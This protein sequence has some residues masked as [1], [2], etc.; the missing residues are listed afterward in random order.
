MLRLSAQKPRRRT[1]FL[2]CNQ[3]FGEPFERVLTGTASPRLR[4]IV[5]RHRKGGRAIS[6]LRRIRWL[7][8]IDLRLRRGSGY[9]REY[10]VPSVNTWGFRC[11]IP[12]HAIGIIAGF[13]EIFAEDTIDS[14]EQ[15][16]NVHPSVLPYYRGPVPSY[17]ALKNAEQRS[18]FTVHE[19]TT[20]ID[21]GPILH[22]GSVQIPLDA[23]EAELDHQIAETAAPEVARWLSCL[24]DNRTF[25]GD[26]LDPASIYNHAVDYKSFPASNEPA[27]KS[28]PRIFIMGLTSLPLGSMEWGNLG[29]Y[30][31]IEP[32][33]RLLQEQFPNALIRTSLQLSDRFCAEHRITSLRH[34]RFWSYGRRTLFTTGADFLRAALNLPLRTL[35]PGTRLPTK[36]SL[37]LRELQ[38][39][40]LVI[41]F[42]GDRY[43]DNVTLPIFLEGTARLVLSKILLGKPTVMLFSSPGPFESR[44]RRLLA[45]LALRGLDLVA[46]RE[47]ASTRLLAQYGIDQE[48]VTTS[49]CPSFLFS[50]QLNLS[51]QSQIAAAEGL[52][53]PKPTVGIIVCDLNMV[54]EPLERFPRS[55][56]DL[57]PFLSLIAYLV[58]SVGVRVCIMSH[59]N[60]PHL[61]K[62][63]DVELL[64]GMDHRII[65]QLVRE[66]RTN[67][68]P[69]DVFTLSRCYSAEE[70]RIIIST[71]TM[72]ISGRIHGAVQGLSQSIP[73][74]IIDYGIGP[75]AHKLQGM[76]ELVGLEHLICS[77]HAPNE[78]ISVTKQAWE[79]RELI[80]AHLRQ[81]LPQLHALAKR[82]VARL[83]PLA[84][85]GSFD[86]TDS[87]EHALN[88]D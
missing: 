42:S 32:F 35:R 45:R 51:A 49:V 3:R 76:A 16:V 61:L 64:P 78:L 7:V 33:I 87:A 54:E 72:L 39:A 26:L 84:P 27:G 28:A 79:E 24:L 83:A 63:G 57:R 44:V 59:E 31:I 37:L 5:I 38:D 58:E 36:S 1:L 15:L 10:E 4:V 14:F 67:Y 80:A 88:Q 21:V 13:R 12:A 30:T 69:E 66:I 52:D 62:N 46:N 22:Q 18:G 2:F 75:R 53:T 82:T 48:H 23:T 20:R 9:V 86:V 34:P 71:F 77:P 40:D 11:R 17:W 68:G 85:S 6:A 19:V 56:K 74:V 73:T 70:S 65:E 25:V 81:V 50:P 41:D 29:N 55:N 60:L 8:H 47:P 43:G